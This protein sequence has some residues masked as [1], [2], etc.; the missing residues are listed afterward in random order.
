MNQ[1]WSMEMQKQFTIC[2]LN[3]TGT[4]QNISTYIKL[5]PVSGEVMGK[6]PISTVS[7]SYSY[8]HK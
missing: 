7:D 6:F 8:M 1:N 3:G 4:G 5:Y 2:V